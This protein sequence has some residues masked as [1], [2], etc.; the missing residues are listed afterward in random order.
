MEFRNNHRAL[1]IG[2]LFLLTL[3]AATSCKQEISPRLK[4]IDH[5]INKDYKIGEQALDSMERLGLLEAKP[6]YMYS[7]LLRLKI[8]DKGYQPI[9]N[10]KKEIDSLVNYFQG[11]KDGDA[12]A[13]AYYLAGR[14]NSDLGDSPKAL[15]LYQ[16]AEETVNKDNYALQGDI[17]CQMG[18]IYQHCRLYNDA[19]A[20]FKKAYVA[21]SLNGNN[22]SMLL[23]LRDIGWNLS[24]NDM[25]KEAIVYWKRGI[26]KATDTKN[27]N[28][29]KDLYYSL[30]N[31]YLT[32]KE[33]ALAKIFLSKA[34]DV[35]NN[36]WSKSGLYAVA[37]KYYNETKNENEAIKYEKWLLD[38]GEVW[39]KQ[40]VSRNK[41]D[42]LIKMEGNTSLKLFWTTYKKCS[43]SITKITDTKEVKRI[44]Q[45]YN[46]SI[47]EKENKELEK[48]NSFKTALIIT[49]ILVLINLIVC[50]ILAVHYFKQKEKIL[51]FKIEKYKKMQ[52]E[53]SDECIN[54]L[55]K[56][57][58]ESDIYK[59]IAKRIAR[60]N[61]TLDSNQWTLLEKS[62][63]E[64]YPN[65]TETL[66]SFYDVSQQ[67]LRVCLMIK[68]GIAPGNIAKFT[69]H[70]KEAINS[71]RGRLYAK[72]FKEPA[73]APKWDEFIKTL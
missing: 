47:K 11:Q 15:I 38:S 22:Q 58:K 13:L 23:D 33:Y 37:A 52:E 28:I 4:E 61:F 64:T 19:V 56:K 6:N 9:Q 59:E 46:Y 51:K 60:G 1:T 57:A 25:T 26:K 68:M 73:S 10:R 30:A 12:L 49:I 32:N 7:K 48:E 36:N 71:T 31:I 66:R 63:N 62:I 54:R 34:I 69:N 21:D 65:F 42:K 27:Y 16:K 14:V 40:Y 55:G 3:M 8:A 20:S 29:L 44:E 53:K 43:D 24:A 2:L 18:Y 67:E 39:A 45:I 5:S 41:V 17:Y 35:H 72:V 50:I 70:S